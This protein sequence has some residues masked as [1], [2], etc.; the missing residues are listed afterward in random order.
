[1]AVGE[2][3]YK[4]DTGTGGGGTRFLAE[5]PAKPLSL[6]LPAVANAFLSTSEGDTNLKSR[7]R[8][9]SYVLD[10]LVIFATLSNPPHNS[11]L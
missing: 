5:A 6:P 4:K 2:D 3:I 11:R 1:M 10:N 7:R 9:T 8:L